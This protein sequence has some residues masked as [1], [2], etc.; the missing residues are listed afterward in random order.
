M[1]RRTPQSAAKRARE[2]G[3]REKRELKQAKKDARKRQAEDGFLPDA[4]G[5]DGEP[6]DSA[7]DSEAP[8]DELEAPTES[9]GP[10]DEPEAST[11]DA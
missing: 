1:A 3:L 8:S 2:Q 9:E 5:L 4:L 10:A 7:D 11:D 6:E